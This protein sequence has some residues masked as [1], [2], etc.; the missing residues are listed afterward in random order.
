MSQ[1][2]SSREKDS[3]VSS[4]PA[5]PHVSRR[6]PRWLWWLLGAC[7]LGI[8][9]CT[10][11][12]AVVLWRLSQFGLGTSMVDEL[13]REKVELAAGV[14][15]PPSAR[16]L[17]SH[18]TAFQDY[19]I[20]VRFD[21]DPADMPVFLSSTHVDLPLSSTIP[22]SFDEELN[23]S[24]WRPLEAKQFQAGQGSV[25]LPH[26]YPESQ[27]ILIDTTDPNRYIVYITAFDT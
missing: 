7:G 13:P 24:W 16:N 18:Y 2:G 22:L 19:F 21:M 23:V 14:K 9:T 3:G 5:R 27:S 8:V 26:G 15:L 4:I 20:H 10:L 6:I 25:S 17:H 11:L 1:G 12:G